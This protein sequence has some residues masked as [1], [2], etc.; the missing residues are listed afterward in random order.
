MRQRISP[1][2]WVGAARTLRPTGHRPGRRRDPAH[3]DPPTL[4]ATSGGTRATSVG[5][6]GGGTRSPTTLRRRNAGMCSRDPPLPRSSSTCTPRSFFAA[7]ET[8]LRPAQT[9]LAALGTQDARRYNSPPL[10]T[11]S[12]FLLQGRQYLC[13]TARKLTSACA[14]YAD[15][16]ARV[17]VSLPHAVADEKRTPSQL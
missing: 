9:A 13:P 3:R 5:G 16:H 1:R 8:M 15:C 17:R 6:T 10:S 7:W 12:R 2:R 11:T 4:P 14:G